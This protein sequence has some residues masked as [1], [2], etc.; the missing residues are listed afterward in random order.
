MEHENVNSD[1]KE[2]HRLHSGLVPCTVQKELGR[3]LL[4]LLAYSLAELPMELTT[5]ERPPKLLNLST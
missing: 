4:H 1:E 3:E 2:I 5:H